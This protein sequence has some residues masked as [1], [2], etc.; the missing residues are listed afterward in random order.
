[1]ELKLIPIKSENAMNVIAIAL[2]ESLLNPAPIKSTSANGA[3]AATQP[4]GA[5]PTL[6]LGAIEYIIDANDASVA[7]RYD[8]R[9]VITKPRNIQENTF[10]TK[11]LEATS[12]LTD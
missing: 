12:L 10:E 1:M 9:P 7:N 5:K 11:V 2:Y 8:A 4:I 6:P 3:N